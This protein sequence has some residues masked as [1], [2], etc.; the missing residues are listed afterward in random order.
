MAEQ[1][2]EVGSG[3]Q[4]GIKATDLKTVLVRLGEHRRAVTFTSNGRKGDAKALLEAA[5]RVFSDGLDLQD[6]KQVLLQTQSHIWSG[7]FVDIGEDNIEDKAKI[8]AVLTEACTVGN[9]LGKAD[10]ST[11]EKVCLSVVCSVRCVIRI[12]PCYT[13]I[14]AGTC[15]LSMGM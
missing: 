7:E 9:S 14:I 4:A 1:Q 13:N 8:C 6:D 3:A 5:S 10:A 11:R 15:V 2:A 12:M